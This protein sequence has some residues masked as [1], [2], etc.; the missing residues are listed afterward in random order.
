MMTVALEAVAKRWR[1]CW[2]WPVLHLLG[3]L[4]V[5]QRAFRGALLDI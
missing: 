2:D 3:S 5:P 1:L 4:R